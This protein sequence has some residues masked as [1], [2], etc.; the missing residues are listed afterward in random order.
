MR[1]LLA[2]NYARSKER[3]WRHEQVHYFDRSSER[4][5]VAMSVIL[6]SAE[7]S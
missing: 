7:R 5:R 1:E 4:R 6:P 2:S 3:R